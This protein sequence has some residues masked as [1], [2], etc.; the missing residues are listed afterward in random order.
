MDGNPPADAT[1]LSTMEGKTLENEN[2]PGLERADVRRTAL[3][4]LENMDSMETFVP[5]V[6]M[7]CVLR[8]SQTGKPCTTIIRGILKAAKMVPEAP[9]SEPIRMIQLPYINFGPD[10]KLRY[11]IPKNKKLERNL[12]GI[13]KF[14]DCLKM[15]TLKTY[16][17]FRLHGD[18]ESRAAFKTIAMTR[19]AGTFNIES[20]LEYGIWPTELHTPCAVISALGF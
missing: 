3:E 15:D 10:N 4:F 2:L 16:F 7:W 6:D 14:C 5:I 1:E 17:S 19:Y 11:F 13:E 8:Q 18:V 12:K 9:M 20:L